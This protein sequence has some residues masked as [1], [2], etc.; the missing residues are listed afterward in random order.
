[1]VFCLEYEGMKVRSR[2]NTHVQ[3][4]KR[5]FD[6][7]CL[8]FVCICSYYRGNLVVFIRVQLCK[9]L[10]CV[11]V[12]HLYCSENRF[13]F[14]HIQLPIAVVIV[15]VECQTCCLRARQCMSATQ[16]VGKQPRAC[17][18]GRRSERRNLHFRSRLA[19]PPQ[20]HHRTALST[21]PANSR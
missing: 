10:V 5:K 21:L 3:E 2:A 6:C 18:C 20:R 14:L 13:N 16:T 15:S 19:P 9:F 4:M 12:S 8:K 1:M 7:I 11:F 17:N